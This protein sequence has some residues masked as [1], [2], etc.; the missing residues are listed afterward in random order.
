MVD[1]VPQYLDPALAAT[2]P[3]PPG[4]SAG[5]YPQQAHAAGLVYW[6]LGVSTRAIRQPFGDAV[7][8]PL[9]MEYDLCPTNL[10]AVDCHGDPEHPDDRSVVQI[11]QDNPPQAG[12]VFP[13][14][15]WFDW[16]R[17]TPPAAATFNRMLAIKTASAFV[18]E[19]VRAGVE[20]PV[21]AVAS[22]AANG[23]TSAGGLTAVQLVTPG[24][25]TQASRDCPLVAEDGSGPAPQPLRVPCWVGRWGFPGVAGQ[26]LAGGSTTQQLG[27]LLKV[28]PVGFSFTEDAANLRIALTT[29]TPEFG[30]EVY[31]ACSYTMAFVQNPASYQT[32]DSAQPGP[33]YPC[34]AYG[35]RCWKHIDLG[36]Y[37]Q[38]FLTPLG[39]A[40]TAIVA[41]HQLRVERQSSGGRYVLFSNFSPGFYHQKG[42]AT[43]TALP[44]DVSATPVGFGTTTTIMRSLFGGEASLNVTITVSA[45]GTVTACE[46]RITRNA[47]VTNL[48]PGWHNKFVKV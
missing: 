33:P 24:N 16:Q 9:H 12:R 36:A 34:K 17:S 42:S 31:G 29:G 46:A 20:R 39:D 2:P 32:T 15:F 14:W 30:C 38:V 23:G 10:I 48:G 35:D 6:T 8:A 27:F 47:A 18:G 44:A 37:I 43:S 5:D 1:A 45:T 7:G 22:L 13:R 28:K 11:A 19:E 21:L 40:W 4:L 25:L 3:R 41:I 26:V